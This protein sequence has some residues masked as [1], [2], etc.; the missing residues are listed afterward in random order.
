MT[1]KSADGFSMTWTFD[2]KLR[3]V[4]RRTT[5]QSSDIKVGTTVGVAGAKDGDN[6]VARLVVVPVK[7]K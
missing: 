4:E 1:V 5:V 2:E 6:G 7:Q 3:V